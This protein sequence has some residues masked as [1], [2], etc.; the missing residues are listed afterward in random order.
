VFILRFDMRAPQPGA[1][2]VDL[3]DAALEM[4]AWSEGRG[5]VAAVVCEHHGS[6]DGYLPSPLVLGAAI[7]ARTEQLRIMLAAVLLPFYDVVRLAEDMNVL[8]LV[9]RGRV[10]YVFGIGYRPEEFE[11]FGVERRD[12]GRVAEEK[13]RLL[14]QLRAGDE[15]VHDGRRIRVTPAPFT[16][17]GPSIL[18]GGGS[19]AAALRAGRYGLGLQANADTPGLREAYEAECRAHGREPGF[20][21]VPD[22]SEPS[23]VFVADDVDAAWAELGP[24]LLHDARMYSEWNPGE[25]AI[26]FISHAQSVNELR[27]TGTGYRILSRDEAAAQVRAGGALRLAPL[28]GGVPPAIAWPYLENAAAASTK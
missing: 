4:C 18:W 19:V 28:C 17:G 15:V 11:Q 5:G 27:A 13:L 10:S 23:V 3:Y 16:P 12:R 14:L 7:A 25:G 6:P 22:P 24:Y 9:S 20:V 1:A 26:S 8:D 21:H 2:P